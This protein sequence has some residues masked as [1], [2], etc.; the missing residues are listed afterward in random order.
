[1]ADNATNK[2]PDNGTPIVVK[3]LT[4]SFGSQKVLNG[5][6]FQVQ[7]AETL[8]VLGRSG[9][10]KSVLLKLMIGLQKPNSGSLCIHGE[11]IPNL[12]PQ[13]IDE[14]RKKMGFLFQ[15]GAL[16]DSLTVEENVTFPLSR[17]TR[18]SESERKKRARE[19][20]HSVGMEGD[21]E[22]MPSQIS[23]GMQKRVGLARALALDPDIL[24]SDEPTAGLDPI[25][26]EE[27]GGLIVEMKKQRQMTSVVVT[28]DIHQAKVFADRLVLIDQGHV[29]MEG[30]FD[31]LQKSEDEFVRRFLK[32]ARC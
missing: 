23:G 12:S 27:I 2:A 17:H 32:D 28:H 30:T 8:A 26:A 31:D 25:T 18:L 11:E 3:D 16:Y 6:S 9:T 1:M 5:I 13:Q 29:V 4:K 10:G 19:L 22:K 7:H 24:L 21:G 20:L 14:L 15:Q